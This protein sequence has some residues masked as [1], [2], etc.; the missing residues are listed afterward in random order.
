MKLRLSSGLFVL[1]AVVGAGCSSSTSA[2][3]TTPEAGPADI[4]SSTTSGGVTTWVV[5]WYMGTANE[6]T[7]NGQLITIHAGDSV[8]WFSSDGQAHTVEPMGTGSSPFPT[9]MAPFTTQSPPITFTT[10]GSFPY[11]CGVHGSTFMKGILTVQ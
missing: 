1:A 10:A 2:P 7:G 4:K 6:N 11:E 9:G 8:I 3:A 5:N